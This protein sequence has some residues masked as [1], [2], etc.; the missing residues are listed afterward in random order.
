MTLQA[1]FSETLERRADRPAIGFAGIR[2]DI[3]WLTTTEFHRESAAKAAWL[4][5]IGF[6]PPLQRSPDPSPVAGNRLRIDAAWRQA[7][8]ID[9]TVQAGAKKPRKRNAIIMAGS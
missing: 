3:E 4:R 6:D 8:S 1:A 2:G 7:S 5:G 9:V